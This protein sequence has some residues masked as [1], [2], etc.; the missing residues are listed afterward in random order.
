[1]RTIFLF[2]VFTTTL[3]SQSL[4]P[5]HWTQ[6][7]L[8]Y[9][10]HRGGLWQHS[11]LSGPY[12][13]EVLRPSLPDAV[14]ASGIGFSRMDALLQRLPQRDEELL[15]WIESRD[16]YEKGPQLELYHGTQRARFGVRLR[17]W[18]HIYH[19]VLADNR[20]DEDHSY[21]GKRQAGLAAYSEQAVMVAHHKQFELK[22]GRDFL[23]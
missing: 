22:F 15:F 9:L 6:D 17:P 14:A 2:F 3:F 16:A 5:D 10:Y 11:P 8:R 7:Y 19:T 20:I 4:H 23:T 13:W 21:R 1:M 12:E 18:L